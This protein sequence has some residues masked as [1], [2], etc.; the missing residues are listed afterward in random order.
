MQVPYSWLKEL[1]DVPWPSEELAQRLTLAGAEAETEPLFDGE[2]D[3]ICV[4]QIVALDEIKGSDHLKTALVNTGSE[5]LQVVCGAPNAAKGQKV[6]FAEIGATLAGGTE[7]KKV[8]LR[9][10]ESYGMICSEAELGLSDDHSGI[11]VLDGDASVGQ[12]AIEYLQLN[13]PII[14]LDLTPNRADLM[15]AIGVA[16]EAACLSGK[17]VERPVFE[18]AE[19]PEKASDW[20]KV[21]IDDPD[22]CPRYAARII[23]GV[24]IGPSPWWIKRKLLLCGIRPIS[25]IV[26]VTNLVMME[27]GHPLHA[28]DYDLFKRKEILVRRAREGEF[29]T[30]LDGKKHE[31]TPDVLLITDGEEGVAAAGVMGGL[32]S[33]VSADTVNILLESAYFDSITIRKSRIKLGMVSESSARFEKGAD[34]NIVPEAVNWAAYLMQKYAGGEVL[35]GIVDCYPKKITPVRIDLRPERVNSLLGTNISRERIVNIL[36]GLEFEVEDKGVLKVTVPTFAVDVIREVDLIEEIV[37]VEGYDSIPS[38]D[39]NMGPLFTPEQRDAQFRTE[40]RSV[41]TAAGFDEVLGS[42]FAETRLLSVLMKDRP[43]LKILNP[44]AED[45]SVVQNNLLYSLLKAVAHNISHRNISLRLFEIGKAF[46]PG[47]PPTEREQIGLALSGA[48]ESQWYLKRKEPSFYDLKGAIDSFL[49]GCHVEPAEFA[50]EPQWPFLDGFSFS[51]KI[52]GKNVGH[53]GQIVEDVTRPFDIKQPVLAAVL[54]FE[55]VL[56]SQRLVETYR[57]LPRFPRP[58]ETWR[59]LSTIRYRSVIF[60]PRFAMPPG[61][62]WKR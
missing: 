19:A 50:A 8:K 25:N 40:I 51:V 23:K 38:V 24:K 13:D 35:S 52:S 36:Q 4:G 54:D 57:A 28:F 21:S 46:Q 15:S 45:L 33:E 27:Y 2:F 11:M 44:I 43:Q 17:K 1:V 61:I 14:K 41:M 60:C 56:N 16:R 29:F 39:R 6:I 32:E 34:P 18:I 48:S 31:L 20:V 53:A 58:R 5:K 9:G 37:R 47:D 3:N 7:I 22:A 62:Y 30:T 49:E 26:V 42:G 59:L 12:P 10:V 55:K